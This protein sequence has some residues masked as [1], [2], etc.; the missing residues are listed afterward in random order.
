MANNKYSKEGSL[1]T[2][3]V[4]KLS[5]EN[6]SLQNNAILS[7]QGNCLLNPNVLLYNKEGDSIK[8][9]EVDRNEYTLVFRYTTQCCSTCVER[10]LDKMLEF[11][12]RHPHIDILLLTN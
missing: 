10:I 12:K 7:K 1:L 9:S 5:F 4:N 11:G 8:L 2:E 3:K 6:Y